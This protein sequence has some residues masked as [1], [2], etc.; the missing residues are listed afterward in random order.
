MINLQE[1]KTKLTKVI[2]MISSKDRNTETIKDSLDSVNRMIK[3]EFLDIHK[4]NSISMQLT[5]ALKSVNM[6]IGQEER[7][8]E[9]V[10][11]K[12]RGF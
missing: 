12:S 1:N 7:E 4:L 5:L 10:Y 9:I 2:E 3:S 8:M 11:N 6:L